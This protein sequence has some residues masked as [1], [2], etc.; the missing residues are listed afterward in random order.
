MDLNRLSIAWAY[1]HL[2]PDNA[3]VA[4]ELGSDLDRIEGLIKKLRGIKNPRSSDELG[5][6]LVLM[7]PDLPKFALRL[8][9]GW[10]EYFQ[11]G[12]E[13][14]RQLLSGMPE[15]TLENTESQLYLTK[16]AVM[17]PVT[18]ELPEDRS[19][20]RAF[21]GSAAARDDA[22]W[23]GYAEVRIGQWLHGAL[24]AAA[25]RIGAD[26]KLNRVE[27]REGSA[28]GNGRGATAHCWYWQD[29]G[30]RHGL[31]VDL[32]LNDAAWPVVKI[33]LYLELA[34]KPGIAAR[35]RSSGLELAETWWMYLIRA[36]ARKLSLL[37]RAG[38][39]VNTI[40]RARRSD[41]HTLMNAI[42]SYSDG[43]TDLLR[44]LAAHGRA[45]DQLPHRNRMS[46]ARK[47]PAIVESTE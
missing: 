19:E 22:L 46:I 6:L 39:I 8:E 12:V 13:R 33:S 15:E 3:E 16:R 45:L 25:E 18:L 37:A 40:L 35:I 27:V 1:R 17:V 10:Y 44:C 32:S 42:E 7:R 29:D 26:A 21:L 9:S 23:Q 47:L 4:K 38:A 2:K 5:E 20:L 31:Q 41:L 24:V 36:R 14:D 43:P 34:P 30:A 28:R 11:E